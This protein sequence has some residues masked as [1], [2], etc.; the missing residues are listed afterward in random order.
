MPSE[1]PAKSLPQTAKDDNRSSTLAADSFWAMPKLDGLRWNQSYPYRLAIWTKESG[2]WTQDTSG[3]IP[4]FTLPIPPESL[5]ISTPFAINTIV[6]LGGIVEEH[7]GAP[8]RSISITGT[9][10]VLPLRGNTTETPAPQTSIASGIMTGVNTLVGAFG[11]TANSVGMGG[12]APRPNLVEF[13]EGGDNGEGTGYY[14]FKLLQ[15]FLEAYVSVK[16][17]N[18]GRNLV[19]AL[20]MWKDQEIYFVSP[21]SF[22]MRRSA[23]SPLEYGYSLN[24]RGWKRVDA[25]ESPNPVFSHSPVGRSPN[26]LFQALNA[27][28]A[29]RRTIEASKD[30]LNGV[31]GDI[32]AVLLNPLR[33]VALFVKDALGV[34][35]LATDLPGNIIK[36]LKKAILEAK[37]TASGISGQIKTLSQTG[38]KAESLVRELSLLTSKSETK[39]GDLTSSGLGTSTSSLTSHPGNKILDN[40]ESNFEFFSTIKPGDLNLAI[41]TQRQITEEKQRVKSLK[42]EDFEKIRDSFMDVLVDFQSAIGLDNPTY[43]SVYGTPVRAQTRVATDADFEIIFNLNAVIMEINRLAASSTI[44][45]GHITSI[46]YI[47]GLASRSGIAFTT[48]RSKFLAPFPYGYTLEQLSL[49][50]LG[51]PDRWHEIAS[52]NGLQS[53]YVDETGFSLSLLT[54]G[55]KNTVVVSDI[56]NLYVNQSVWISSSTVARTNRRVVKLETLSPTTHRVTL[57]GDSDLEKFVVSYSPVLQGFLPNTINSQMS[58]YIPS[59]TEADDDFRQKSIPGINQFDPLIRVGGVDLL[60]DQKNDL[61]ITPT[62]ETKLAVGMNNIIQK[63]RLAV[64]T[65]K[66]SLLHHT[67]YGFPFQAGD[68]TA[69]VSASDALSQVRNLFSGDPTFSGVQSAYVI[70]NGPSVTV[71]ISVGI[72]G[73]TQ[74]IPVTI[75][76]PR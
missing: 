62:G 61:I 16:K 8:L 68:S 25:N 39:A 12:S 23:A 4:A 9:T 10:G 27:I 2:T 56:A 28:E 46:D 7:N 44:D 51:T 41:Q 48:P 34:A 74:V 11:Q 63:I 22:D 1:I 69:D 6:T 71:S 47:A 64:T 67:D 31:R 17:T 76:L 32:Q 40:P 50:Y 52:L 29:G 26:K 18:T 24:F 49:L 70:K 38:Q 66:G 59:D 65:A 33:Q 60:L 35:I 19:L 72:A 37:G 54:N 45:F 14:Q 13:S 58:I 30:V 36:D 43:A 21:V 57:S 15:R 75:S 55:M 5:T 53:P 20:E 73:T 3:K 42:R